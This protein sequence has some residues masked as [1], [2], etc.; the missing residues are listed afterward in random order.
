[1]KS[2]IIISSFLFFGF[3]I[4]DDDTNVYICDSKTATKYHLKKDCRGLNACKSK[5]VKITLT[6]AKKEKKKLCGWED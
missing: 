1:M 6:D 2:L 3:T 4:V 5:V